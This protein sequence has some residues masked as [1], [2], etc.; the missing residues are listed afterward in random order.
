MRQIVW[1]LSGLFIAAACHAEASAPIEIKP[2]DDVAAIVARAPPGATLHLQPGI[3]RMQYARPKDGQQ[4]IGKGEVIFNGSTILSDWRKID[5][6]WVARGPKERLTP[7]GKCRDETPLCAHREDLFLDGKPYLRVGS[8]ADVRPGTMYDDGLSV[9][10]SDDP[11]GKL[12]ELGVLPFAFASDAEGV[13]LQD[14]IVEKYAS[15][16]Q[17]GTI[18][19]AEG[20]NWQLRNVVARLN[21]G[22]GAR[23]G[24]GT[25]VY[26]GAFNDNGQLGIGGGFGRNVLIQNVEIARNNYAGFSIGWE[27]GGTKFVRVDGLLVRNTCVHHNVGPG[28]WTDIDNINVEF[29]DNLVFDNKGDGIKHEISYAAKIHGNTVARN[30]HGTLNWLWRSQILIQNSQDVEVYNNIV[31]VGPD[32]GNGISVINQKRGKGY[33]GPWVARNNFVHNNTIIHLGASGASGMVA[34]HGKDWFDDN[35]G[36]L[37]DSN[38]Y[39]VPHDKRGYFEVKDGRARFSRLSDYAMERNGKVQIAERKPLKLVCSQSQ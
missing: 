21:H 35:S 15:A 29:V 6:L 38:T 16:A 30:G 9:H 32:Y 19:F 36:N 18:E 5:G 10:I 31:E 1:S 27:A 12:T 23:I 22:V 13:L 4:I 34:D 33:H 20:R 39:V 24:P 17:R 26:G 37:F 8:R 2:D 25:R 11:T 3:Y 28:L 7:A 14:I